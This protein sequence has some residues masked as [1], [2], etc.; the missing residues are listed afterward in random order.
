MSSTERNLIM[1]FDHYVVTEI[2]GIN[3]PADN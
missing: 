3:I 2:A 1:L